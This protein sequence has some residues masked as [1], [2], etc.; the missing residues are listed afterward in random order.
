MAEA[1]LPPRRIVS[2]PGAQG[3]A[4]V[5]STD[6]LSLVFDVELD[7]SDPQLRA[8]FPLPKDEVPLRGDW[9]CKVFWRGDELVCAIRHGDLPHG[10]LGWRT[11]WRGGL[12]WRDTG[13]GG[14]ICRYGYDRSR[15]PRPNKDDAGVL[16]T[17]LDLTVPRE[18]FKSA[19]AHSNGVY[20]SE[21][22]RQY[23]IVFELRQDKR[24][25][26]LNPAGV[27]NRLPGRG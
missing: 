26:T 18:A 20:T 6:H 23:R 22:H 16:F 3:T 2:F 27:I 5:E 24:C 17:G 19:S 13:S 1:T 21:T 25:P 9:A 10:A 15:D 4:A 8:T 7:L 11:F 12:R 14:A